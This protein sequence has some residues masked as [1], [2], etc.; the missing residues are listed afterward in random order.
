MCFISFNMHI[1]KSLLKLKNFI[2]K[3]PADSFSYM[4]LV[5][6]AVFITVYHVK[7]IQDDI[8]TKN[9]S[10]LIAIT[11]YKKIRRYTVCLRMS[12]IYNS[13]TIYNQGPARQYAISSGYRTKTIESRLSTVVCYGAALRIW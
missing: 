5:L 1:L 13:E 2:I 12:S 7:A 4:Y 9:C 10:H 6:Y 3:I 8:S 11:L